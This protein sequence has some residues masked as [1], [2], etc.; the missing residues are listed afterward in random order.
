MEDEIYYYL[1]NFNI[2]T[3]KFIPYLLKILEIHDI[4]GNLIADYFFDDFLRYTYRHMIFFD[5]F[6]PQSRVFAWKRKLC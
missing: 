5:L 1:A 6:C 2:D 4:E 3:L